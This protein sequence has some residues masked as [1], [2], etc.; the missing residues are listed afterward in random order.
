MACGDR[1][2]KSADGNGDAV[3]HLEEPDV[4]L[5]SQEDESQTKQGIDAL[6]QKENKGRKS[7]MGIGLENVRHTL[8]KYG[9]GMMT[10]ALEGE[11]VVSITIPE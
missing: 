3:E 2:T 6:E 7:H 1:D 5:M 9:G 8:E 10:E 4:Q 11:F